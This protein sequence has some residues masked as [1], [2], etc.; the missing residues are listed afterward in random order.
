MYQSDGTSEAHT[1]LYSNNMHYIA[2]RSGKKVALVP[3]DTAEPQQ[4]L[5]ASQIADSSAFLTYGC[6]MKRSLR[7]TQVIGD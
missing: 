4:M 3:Q 2:L 1:L 6:V 5:T 7:M